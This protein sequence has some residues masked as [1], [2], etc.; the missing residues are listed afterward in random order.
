MGFFSDL[1]F[2]I[3]APSSN[4]RRP[5]TG[6]HSLENDY[7]DYYET[8]LE[9]GHALKKCVKNLGMIGKVSTNNRFSSRKK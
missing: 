9:M 4:N 7:D 8:T 5:T 1:L 3:G 6:F 2:D